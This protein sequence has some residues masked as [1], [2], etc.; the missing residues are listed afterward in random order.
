MEHFLQKIE[1]VFMRV[2]IL[3]F[4]LFST[5]VHSQTKLSGEWQGIY[6]QENQDW[7]NGKAFYLTISVINGL[8][9]GKIREEVINSSVYFVSKVSG[10]TTDKNVIN[11]KED[12]LLKQ[13]DKSTFFC[14]RNLILTYN[15]KT[16]YFEGTIKSTK[17]PELQGKILLYKSNFS[18]NDMPESLMNHS[19]FTRFVADLENGL[20]SPIKR[21]E[22]LRNFKFE[23]VYFDYGKAILK[24]TYQSY[25]LEMIRMVKSHSDLRIKITGHTDADGSDS[26]ND[27]LSKKRTEA[28][29]SFFEANGLRRE[30]VVVD[31]KGEKKPVDSNNTDD[32]KRKNRRVDFEFI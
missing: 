1:Y 20:S 5:L 11:L 8:I 10:K 21:L 13:S 14:S 27:Q 16:G 12:R 17:C 3:L 24:E 18:F 26:Y 6:V 32:G 15:E 22:E 29:I 19:W 7:K 28:I 30:R 4:I 23:S 9:D 31:F 2:F 25:L